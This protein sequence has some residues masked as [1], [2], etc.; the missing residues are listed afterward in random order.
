MIP[1]RREILLLFICATSASIAF[2]ADKTAF[3]VRY[4]RSDAGVAQAAGSLPD[5]LESPEALCWRVPLD[6]GH[7]TPI[8]HSGRIF[9]TTWRAESRELATVALDE[10]SGKLLWRNPL[11]PKRIEQTHQLGSPA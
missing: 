5:N 3:D 10:A 11:M 1:Y 6:G 4:F 2:A 9:L 8:L 7:S